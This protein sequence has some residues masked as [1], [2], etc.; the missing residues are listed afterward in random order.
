MLILD[1]TLLNTQASLSRA[2]SPAILIGE[3]HIELINLCFIGG[4]SMTNLSAILSSS[5]LR[6]L[7][8]SIQLFESCALLFILYFL[9]PR[10]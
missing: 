7:A 1:G 6:S 10:K 2:R 5:S 8:K 4:S 9:S 3:S